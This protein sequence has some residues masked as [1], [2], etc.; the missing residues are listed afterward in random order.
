MISPCISELFFPAYDF[1][2][3]FLYYVTERHLDQMLE[4]HRTASRIM[5]FFSV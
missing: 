4:I 1:S 2:I 5:L 3:V